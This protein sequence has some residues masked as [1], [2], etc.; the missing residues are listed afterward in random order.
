MPGVLRLSEEEAIARGFIKPPPG[1]D[2]SSFST[3][4]RRTKTIVKYKDQRFVMMLMLIAGW[5]AGFI[6]ALLFI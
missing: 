6:C 5:M 3:G 4:S 1:F 2:A